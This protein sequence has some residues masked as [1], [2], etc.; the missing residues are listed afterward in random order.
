MEDDMFGINYEEGEK[1]MYGFDECREVADWLKTRTKIRPRVGIICGSGL[2][3]LA[4]ILKDSQAFKYGDIPNFPTSTVVGHKGRLVFGRL[5]G[6]EVLCMQGRFHAYEGYPLMKFAFPV[7]VM[8]FLGA[9]VM[10]VTNAAGG[11]NTGYKMGNIMVLKDHINFPGFSGNNPLKGPNDPRFGPRFVAMNHA[12]DKSLRELMLETA[13][14][15]GLNFIQEGTYVMLAG[16]S[17]ETA[18]EAKALRELGAD[19]TGMSVAHEVIIAVHLGMRV[20]GMSLITNMVIQD[21]ESNL[22][23]YHEEVLDTAN[24]RAKAMQRL[25]TVF[26]SKMEAEHFV[27]VSIRSDIDGVQ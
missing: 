15:L 2:G 11:L 10:M 8:R 12:Y 9:T 17:Y 7:R 21:V 14:E 19:A 23:P 27:P 26:L 4:E 25:V 5:G 22:I 1:V 20:I 6:Q 16:P 13:D 3:G 18:T 24:K